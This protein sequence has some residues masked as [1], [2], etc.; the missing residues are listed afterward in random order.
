MH[1]L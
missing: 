1:E